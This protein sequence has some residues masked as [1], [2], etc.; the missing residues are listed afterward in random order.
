VKL[1]TDT[2][3]LV[4][5]LSEPEVLGAQ[6]RVALAEGLSLATKDAT[7]ARYWAPVVWD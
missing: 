1:L 4:W 7:L 5:A 3:T 2:H 6:A